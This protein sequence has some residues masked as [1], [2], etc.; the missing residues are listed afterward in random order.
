MTQ[1]SVALIVALWF[2]VLSTA[3]QQQR[4]R[5]PI[6]DIHLH[7]APWAPGGAADSATVRAAQRAI[8]DSLDRYNV[9]L[10][11]A[12]GSYPIARTWAAAA[13]KR[14]LAAAAFPCEKGRMPNAGPE[15]FADGKVYPD[16]AW[17]RR[18][19][20]A[21][22]LAALGEIVTQYAGLTPS[23]PSMEPYWQFAEQL[24][25]P[26]FIHVG[27]GPPGAAYPNGICGKEACAP[28]YRMDLS[29]PLLLEP[30]LRKHSRLRVVVMHA[31]WPNLDNLLGLMYAHPQVYADIAVWATIMP[32]DE[33][34]S[35]LLRIVRAGYGKRILYG[36][37]LP[38]MGKAISRIADAPYLTA[39]QKKDILHDNAARFLRLDATQSLPP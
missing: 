28:H 1:R 17:L 27:P 18:E 5:P 33:Y 15:C 26:V 21:G 34:Q 35:E 20:R 22:R 32:P 19:Y 8:L 6:I 36:S 4:D 2:P 14:I 31:G 11:I 30:V 39:G 12:S 16:T 25:I 38:D 24:D 37:D 3:Q 13:P 23:D 7:T 29:D 9:V 10:A